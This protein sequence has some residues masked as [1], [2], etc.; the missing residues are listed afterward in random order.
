MTAEE[1][2]VSVGRQLQKQRQ[3][4]SWDSVSVFLKDQADPAESDPDLESRLQDNSKQYALRIQNVSIIVA[5][6]SFR[7]VEVGPFVNGLVSTL[8]TRT[9]VLDAGSIH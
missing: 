8:I 1:A 5:S 6:S 3:Y 4:E 7:Y 2:F 9:Y